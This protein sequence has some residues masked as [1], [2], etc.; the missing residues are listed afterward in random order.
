MQ[1][2]KILFSVVELCEK[3]TIY[4]DVNTDAAHKHTARVVI[5]S[6]V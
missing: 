4:K 5:H 6:S 1:I 2:I 3:E